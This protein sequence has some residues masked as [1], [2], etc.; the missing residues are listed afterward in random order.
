M[1]II[2]GQFPTEI[3]IA[4]DRIP[5]DS[6][7]ADRAE[8]D[9]VS[10]STVFSS[11]CA[12]IVI[13]GPLVVY[14][15]MSQWLRERFSRKE[16]ML[17]SFYSKEPLMTAKVDSEKHSWPRPVLN[18]RKPNY[19]A[20]VGMILLQIVI[21][22][23]LMLSVMFRWVIVFIFMSYIVM[24]SI[25]GFDGMELTLHGASVLSSNIPF[26]ESGR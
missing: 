17:S 8:Q 13:M 5:M 14:Q 22:L 23:G 12:V 21:L 15:P 25:K 20:I 2:T 16:D 6:I 3:H 18:Y 4:I 11:V 26:S 10:I 24:S 1:R 7:P 19:V 9:K